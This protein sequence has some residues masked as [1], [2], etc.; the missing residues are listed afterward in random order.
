VRAVRSPALSLARRTALSTHVDARGRLIEILR[1]PDPAPRGHQV[2]LTTAQPGHVKGNHYHRRKT[3]WFF[4]L[5]GT[6]R[7]ALRSRTGVEESFTLSAAQPE[8]VEVP[9]LVS[10]ALRNEGSQEVLV[11]VCVDELFD[12]SDPDTVPDLLL[13]SAES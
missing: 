1:R 13:T 11:L 4:V 2:L 10:H 7:M 9:P 6:L 5:A 12:P 3:E 8:L